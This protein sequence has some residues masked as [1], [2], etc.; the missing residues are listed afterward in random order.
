[1]TLRSNT[2]EKRNCS[3]NNVDYELKTKTHS[4]DKLFFQP[5]FYI[6]LR[7]VIL[8]VVKLFYEIP[9]YIWIFTMLGLHKWLKYFLAEVSDPLI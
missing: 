1:M 5:W 8:V 4:N 3:L 7:L 6:K 2:F 9:K